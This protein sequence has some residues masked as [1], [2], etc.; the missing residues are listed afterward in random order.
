MSLRI[1]WVMVLLAI[2]LL[3]IPH[4]LLAEEVGDPLTKG[5]QEIGISSGYGWS[6]GA[7]RCINA[8]PLNVRWGCMFTDPQGCSFFRGIWEVLVEGSGSYLYNGPRAYG[9]GINGL[10]RYNFLAGKRF[11]PFF[12][13]GVG[14]W[15][16]NL[17]MHNF[18]S[19]FNFCSQVGPGVS[20]F[21]TTKAALQAEYRLQHYSNASLYKNNSGLNMSNFWVGCAYFF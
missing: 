10:L 7:E 13:G 17:D 9:I 19:D 5:T 6:I 2:G 4:V 1:H 16:S 20:F 18:P 21:L 15:H 12:Q 11:I 8:V 14:V 3:V